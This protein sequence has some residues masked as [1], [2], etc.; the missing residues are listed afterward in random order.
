M[1]VVI[2]CGGYGTRLREETESKPKP[3][4][5]I[6]GKPILWHIMKTYAHYGYKDFVLCL[7][8]KAEVIKN[9]FL[10]YEQLNSDFSIELGTGKIELHNHHDDHGWRVTLV[11]TGLH[12]MT[13]ARVKRIEQY[14]DDDC[15]MLTYGDGVTDLDINALVKFHQSNNS[16]GTVTG[17][18]PP[19]HYGELGIVGEKVVSFREKP[20]EQGSFISGGYFVFNREFFSFLSG[21]DSCVLEREPIERLS[22]EAQLGVYAYKGFWQCMDTYRDYLYLNE[23]WEQGRAPWKVWDSPTAT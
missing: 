7:G 14:I 12:T 4:V 19:S 1:K 17:V 3:M 21:D 13:G 16:I 11:D 2:L 9:Y 22:E 20:N 10:N 23:L 18:S 5:E 8:Y 15:F 6:G